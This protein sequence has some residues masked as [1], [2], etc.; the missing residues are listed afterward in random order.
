M[1]PTK[2]ARNLAIAALMLYF[3]ANQTQVGWLYVLSA[4]MLGIVL[5]SG[6][7]N[8][9]MLGRVQG[10]RHL[11]NDAIYEGDPISV[12][13]SLRQTRTALAAQIHTTEACPLADPESPEHQM[14][15]FIPQI[16]RN[17]EVSFTYDTVTYR[18]GLHTFAP[19]TL[20]SQAPFGFF[21]STRQLE[22]PTRALVYPEV[23]KLLRLSLLD[24]Q[25]A[26]QQ[27]RP[28]AGRGVEVIGV[29]PFRSGDSP[30][31][32]HWRSVAR[33]QHLMSKEF[34]DEAHP[35]VTLVL[36]LFRHPYP[37]ASTKHTPFEWG[38]KAAASIAEYASR[39]NYALYAT[40]DAAVLPQPPGP[41]SW[42]ALMQ[43]LARVD[44]AG[45]QPLAEA[46]SSQNYQTFVAV[47]IPW[48]DQDILEPLLALQNRGLDLLA[49]VID[50]ESFPAGGASAGPLADALRASGIDVALIR[51]G[52]SIAQQLS[53]T[54]NA[55]QGPF[56]GHQPA[57]LAV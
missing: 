1:R 5:A 22:I 28:R 20:S 7:L 54:P 32:V 4:L 9:S 33:M 37:A 11:S 45:S 50:P 38:I 30:R 41:L 13:L 8:R 53:E 27:T 46:L 14:D 43:Y 56:P 34:A 24:R 12:K 3:F 36:D 15:I 29:R 21:R 19:L 39:R 42:E 51:Y 40:A 6:L 16:P 55:A 23:N 26:A 2:R 44:P 57:G 31:H 48:P 10:E 47:V 49:I 25:P 35:G 18:R 17:G 52:H